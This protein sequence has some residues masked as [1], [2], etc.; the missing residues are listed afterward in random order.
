MRELEHNSKLTNKTASSVNIQYNINTYV[1]T[2]A[3]PLLVNTREYDSKLELFIFLF[4]STEL[5]KCFCVHVLK[6]IKLKEINY[7]SEIVE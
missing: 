7:R 1:C 3:L 2:Q 4:S 5:F 6:F